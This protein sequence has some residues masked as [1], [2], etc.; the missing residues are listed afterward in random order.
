[1]VVF[2]VH[3][4]DQGWMGL[5]EQYH[6]FFKVMRVSFQKQRIR[7]QGVGKKNDPDDSLRISGIFFLHDVNLITKQQNVQNVLLKTLILFK[8]LVD[9]LVDPRGV[10]SKQF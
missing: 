9:R 7:F 2:I 3:V 5:F 6:L 10:L 1:M 8:Y 4:V